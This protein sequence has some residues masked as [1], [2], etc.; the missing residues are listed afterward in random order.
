M[1]KYKESFFFCSAIVAFCI[2]QG[3]SLNHKKGRPHLVLPGLV[4]DCMAVPV[5]G[6]EGAAVGGQ[7]GPRVLP[8]PVPPPPP[9]VPVGRRRA[10]ALALG[11]GRAVDVH[12]PADAERR[13][14]GEVGLRALQGKKSEIVNEHAYR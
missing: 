2:G 4:H 5:A 14:H 8:P 9:P 1:E 12:H 10:A 13:A 3:Q 11:E 7:G 6:G